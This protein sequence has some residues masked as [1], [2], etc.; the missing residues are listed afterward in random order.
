M[1][2]R[3]TYG[4][5]CQEHRWQ[6]PER[7]NLAADVCDKHPRD[8]PAMVWESFD[9]SHR[10]LVWGEL[11]DMAN[12]AAHTLEDEVEPFLLRCGFIQRT[13]RGRV[14]TSAGL[15]H[16]GHKPPENPLRLF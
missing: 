4:R 5:R 14:I 3:D 8:K 16:L 9:G 6:V 1:T 13:P 10:G 7:Y 15:A 2:D 12:R 11:Q